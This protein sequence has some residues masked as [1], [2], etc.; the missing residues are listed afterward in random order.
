MA[1][2]IFDRMANRLCII[3]CQ[4][5]WLRG[6]NGHG[7]ANGLPYAKDWDSSSHYFEAIVGLK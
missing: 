7:P 2:G 3:L 6:G 1:E 5:F 4:I